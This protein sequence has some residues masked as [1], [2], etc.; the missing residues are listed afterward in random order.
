MRPIE[1]SERKILFDTLA[2][3]LGEFRS[4][5]IHLHAS[6]P[7]ASTR[8][9]ASFASSLS[10]WTWM[11]SPRSSN[12][13]HVAK[14]CSQPTSSARRTVRADLDRELALRR[15]RLF[16]TAFA[17][18]PHGCWRRSAMHS[19][20]DDAGVCSD[21]GVLLDASPGSSELAAATDGS[22]T[23]RIE[24][25]AREH[26]IATSLFPPLR[27]L[28]R[29]PICER[30]DRCESV[31]TASQPE[32]VAADGCRMRI[33][34]ALLLSGCATL[35]SGNTTTVAVSASPGAPVTVDGA[36]A[37]TSPTTIVVDNHKS[38]VVVVGNQSCQIAANVGGGWVILDI[39]AGFVPVI[40]DAVTGDWATVDTST[41]RL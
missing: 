17:C 7:Q 27:S 24:R 29:S 34:I 1:E 22:T 12:S 28:T 30:R 16:A 39:L 3:W 20:L 25:Q 6:W 19:I 31:L 32:A 2:V 36:P 10:S 5:M 11:P 35:F 4:S 9:P 14:T 37:G 18:R 33:F 21:F 23:K 38:H 8:P 41:C 26:A 15:W 13:S 40:I